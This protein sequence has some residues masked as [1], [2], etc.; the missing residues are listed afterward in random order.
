MGRPPRIPAGI[1]VTAASFRTVSGRF[2]RTVAA[3]RIAEVLDPPAPTS[4]GRYHR[5]GQPALYTSPTPQWAIL[6]TARYMREDGRRRVVVPLEITGARVIDQRDEAACL[7]L[8]IDRDRSNLPWRLALAEGREP[9]SWHSADIARATGADGIID[10][11]RQ[12]AG[13]WHLNLFRWNALGAPRVEISGDPIPVD[14]ASPEAQWGLWAPS[15]HEPL[16][17]WPRRGPS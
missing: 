17:G 2:Y 11:S 6:A 9:P 10:R 13:G 1:D 12:A 4:A 15:P 8:G 14:P 3:D 7:A 5:L 16:H